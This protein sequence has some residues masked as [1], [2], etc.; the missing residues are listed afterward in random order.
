MPR[1]QYTKYINMSLRMFAQEGKLCI[2]DLANVYAFDLTSL[3][4]IV[5]IKQRASFPF[6]NKTDKHDSA[7]Y[8]KYGIKY[9]RGAFTVKEFYALQLEKDGEE[10]AIYFPSYELPK[11]ERL[12]EITATK[13]K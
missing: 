5:K 11:F 1:H 2:S 4:R 8:E 6:W 3:K 7:M 9:K 10:Y 12:A 13:K